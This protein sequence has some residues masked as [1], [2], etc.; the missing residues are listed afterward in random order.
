LPTLGRIA[1]AR[2]EPLVALEDRARLKECRAQKIPPTVVQT[3]ASRLLSAQHHESAE[4][5]R[6][7]NPDLEFLCF[8]DDGVDSYMEQA[9]GNHPIYGIFQK[10]LFPQLKSDIFRYCI[11]YDKG[12]YYCDVNKA[13]ETQLTSLHSP[14]A[15]GLISYESNPAVIWPSGEVAEALKHPEKYVLQ[16]AFGFAPGHPILSRALER[17]VDISKW[18]GNRSFES[19]RTAIVA[20]TGPGVFTS[21]V[22]DT[23]ADG[24]FSGVEEVGVDFNGLG[25]IRVPGSQLTPLPGKHYSKVKNASLLG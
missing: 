22:F 2:V 17:I 11:I 14:E 6:T 24:A 20:F 23:V 7:V 25:V 4:R 1:Q 12:G 8:D 16:W 15:M 18:V 19:I 10:S 21:A 13:I 5:F 3:F 9:W